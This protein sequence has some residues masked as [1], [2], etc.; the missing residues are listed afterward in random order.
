MKGLTLD[1][2]TLA[3]GLELGR[4]SRADVSDWVNDTVMRYEKLPDALLELTTLAHRETDEIVKLLRALST[5]EE[6]RLWRIAVTMSAEDFRSGACAL[7]PTIERL[8]A[9]GHRYSAYETQ[10]ASELYYLEDGVTLA[11]DGSWGTLDDVREH[12]EQ[13]LAAHELREEG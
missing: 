7:E 4:T 9:A 13:F 1:A 5:S 12:L 8:V 2:D 10:A 6:A 11:T 3:V